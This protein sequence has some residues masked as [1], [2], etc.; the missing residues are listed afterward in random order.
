MLML[1]EE[2]SKAKIGNSFD[3]ACDRMNA[4]L[5][6]HAERPEAGAVNAKTRDRKAK[7]LNAG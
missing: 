6:E 3:R 1:L 2:I 5:Q 4:G 7:A